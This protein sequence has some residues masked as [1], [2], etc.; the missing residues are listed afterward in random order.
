MKNRHTFFVICSILFIWSFGVQPVAAQFSLGGGALYGSQEDFGV[1]IYG[2]YQPQ[3]KFSIKIDG[4][5]WPRTTPD[6]ASQRFSEVNA[7]LKFL[8]LSISKLTFYISGIA[9]YHYAGTKVEDEL[10]TYQASTHM[11][12]LGA[13]G[14]IEYNLGSVSVTLHAR[15]FF[16]GF[17]Q[18]SIGSG[19][20]FNF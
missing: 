2:V 12:A 20:R 14:G 6:N 10:A 7:E 5:W 13:G 18:T 15:T 4:V 16:T 11:T 1:N 3:E 19:I 9:G 17:N 8:P